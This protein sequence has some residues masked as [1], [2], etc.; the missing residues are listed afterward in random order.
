M[1]LS[2]LV[3]I[4]INLDGSVKILIALGDTMQL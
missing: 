2:Y 1:I 3:Y 4:Y